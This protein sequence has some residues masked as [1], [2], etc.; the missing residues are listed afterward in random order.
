[1]QEQQL[2][3]KYLEGRHWEQH[4]TTYAE[5]YAQ[6]LKE[7]SFFGLLVD[8]GCG[9]GRDVAF[10]HQAGQ[11]SMGIDYSLPEISKAKTAHPSCNFLVANCEEIPF[12]DRSVGAY[13]MINVIHYVNPRRALD[14][15]H[16]TL[17]DDG[18]LFLHCNLD[19][20][21]KDG[22][23]DY[24][25]EEEG[26]YSLTSNFRILKKRKFQ[27]VDTTPTVHTHTILELILQK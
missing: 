26:V 19:I 25:R 6:F 14:E 17:Q 20:T 1:M 22:N 21:D 9:S 13:F 10:F 23:N 8:I 11:D 18:Y 27:R 16:R 4:P 3:D 15:L 5:S 12:R 24:H 2:F 7:Q